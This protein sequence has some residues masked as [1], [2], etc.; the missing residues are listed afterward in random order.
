[1]AAS[2]RPKSSMSLELLTMSSKFYSYTDTVDFEGIQLPL[3]NIYRYIT[4]DE[5]G[6]IEA[7]RTK[8]VRDLEFGGFRSLEGELPIC[9]G[10]Q[11]GE[12]LPVVARKYRRHKITRQL[13]S[14]TGK[15]VE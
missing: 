12:S 4:R 3:P 14:L 15:V 7:W 6:F 8:P 1:M 2:T 5:R 13:I 11:S 10:H 9:F